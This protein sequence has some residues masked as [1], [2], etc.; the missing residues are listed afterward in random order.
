MDKGS[1]LS[2]WTIPSFSCASVQEK[3]QFFIDIQPGPGFTFNQV[4]A[5]QH[6][7]RKAELRRFLSCPYHVPAANLGRQLMMKHTY[8][9]GTIFFP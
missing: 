4:Q 9:M 6:G 8:F 2:A 5:S 7:E 1:R 3:H